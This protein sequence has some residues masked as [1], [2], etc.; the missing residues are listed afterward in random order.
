MQIFLFLVCVSVR[1]FASV[2]RFFSG[3]C[4]EGPFQSLLRFRVSFVFRVRAIW[5]VNFVCV[6]FALSPFLFFSFVDARRSRYVLHM[7][8]KRSPKNAPT[9]KK[10]TEYILERTKDDNIVPWQMLWVFLFRNSGLFHYMVAFYSL[11]MFPLRRWMPIIR[12]V[13]QLKLVDF[14]NI[15]TK[16]VLDK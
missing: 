15:S 2:F 8:M 14:P 1:L 7:S 3:S 6:R 11:E 12:K 13:C 4:S 5:Y 9:E 16:I 10:T